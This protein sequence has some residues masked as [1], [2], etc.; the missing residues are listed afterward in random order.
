MVSVDNIKSI[1][2][3]YPLQ[4][5]ELQD[6]RTGKLIGRVPVICIQVGF[7]N[8]EEVAYYV[9]G[10]ESE[11]YGGL[12]GVLEKQQGTRSE[13]KGRFSEWSDPMK[14]VIRRIMMSEGWNFSLWPDPEWMLLQRV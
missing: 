6:I 1:M 3:T 12:S 9:M 7:G 11:K 5:A 4:Y 13:F 8:G 10:V 14:Q 2:V